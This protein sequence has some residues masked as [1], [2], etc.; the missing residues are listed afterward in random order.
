VRHEGW[1]GRIGW[2]GGRGSRGRRAWVVS[3]LCVLC[4]LGGERVISA[5]FQMPDP[6]QMSGIPR[7][8]G[9][10][11]DGSITVLI[12]RGSV[13]NGLPGQTVDLHVGS[14]VQ[15]AKTDDAGRVQ[16][17]KLPAGESL[18]AIAVV[19]GERLE[20][21]TFPA[22]AQGG[23]RLLLAATDK[24]KSGATASA[25][26]VTGQVSFGSQ[27]QLVLQP[28]DGSVAVYYLLEIVNPS[29]TP[30]NPATPITFDMPTGAARTGLLEGSTPLATVNGAHVTV[31]GPF[32]PG[33]TQVRVA[34]ELPS[35]GGDLDIVQRFPAPMSEFSV[36]V[37]KAAPTMKVSSPQLAN[38]KEMTA[39][40]EVFIAGLG[41]ALKANE[42]LS[43]T[44]SD[45][46]HH[47][48]VPRVLALTLAV[49]VVLIGVWAAIGAPRDEGA[50]AAER[51]RLITRRE[52]LLNDLV[53]LEHD[54]RNG[55][56][57]ERR[58]S[59]RREEL[60]TALE[61]V[62]GALDADEASPD[63]ASGAGVA[64]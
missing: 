10:L 32:P 59:I 61:Q 64:A 15:S 57:D 21:Q 17:D 41:S 54:R 8:V 12:V 1:T 55:R 62:Y 19:D 25:P 23:I 29:A 4:V 24:S 58:Y 45:L 22:P 51:K 3:A 47:S 33:S 14:K 28:G 5:Q 39:Q 52:K 13:T 48:S 18:Q 9:D 60:L 31:I 63:P 42:P 36:I 30:V 26:A 46:P 6:K 16:F 20:S 34:S 2:N 35:S 49:V 27:T 50:R 56:T 38:I 44:L 53:R 37:R 7:P 43:L 11:P 40:G